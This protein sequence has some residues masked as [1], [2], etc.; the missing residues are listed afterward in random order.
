M[1]AESLISAR[2]LVTRPEDTSWLERDLVARLATALPGS[3]YH[4]DLRAALARV[5]GT[6]DMIPRERW[7]VLAQWSG[8]VAAGT[9]R[10]VL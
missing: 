4:R 2:L 10:D 9:R 1:S 8:L 3:P 7:R 6:R 5:E